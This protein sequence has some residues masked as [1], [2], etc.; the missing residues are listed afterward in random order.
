M[1]LEAYRSLDDASGAIAAGQRALQFA[2][3]N[4]QVT[5]ELASIIADATTDP[6]QLRQAEDYAHKTLEELKAFTVPKWIPP[7]KWETIEGRLRS[8]AHV[9]LGL[10]AYKRGGLQQAIGEFET[11]IELAPAPEP[12]QYYRLGMLYQASGNKAAAIQK[13]Q[14]AAQLNDPTIRRLAE[15]QLKS[16]DR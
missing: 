14:K 4:L 16:L 12:A 5:A 2:P 10:V 3:G 8:E 1:E 7:Q 6:Q 9:A 11:A 15:K 13:L